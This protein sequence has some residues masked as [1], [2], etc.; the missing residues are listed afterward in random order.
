MS[1]PNS[2]DEEIQDAE[3]ANP[4]TTPEGTEQKEPVQTP[5]TQEIDYKVK[6]TESAKEAQRLY[7]EKKALEEQLNNSQQRVE[8]T[9]TPD[10][11]FF[12][13][14]EEL[15]E[16]AQKNLLAYTDAVER[17]ALDKVYKDP[18]IAFARSTYN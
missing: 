15:D 10:V 18:A 16:E 12:P 6:F 17:R 4:E 1:N 8:I 3:I 7:A 9:T 13:G 5:D 11:E 14:F 2:F